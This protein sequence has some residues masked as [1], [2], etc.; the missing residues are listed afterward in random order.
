MHL[1]PPRITEI[2]IGHEPRIEPWLTHSTTPSLWLSQLEGIATC[3]RETN[4]SPKAK[5]AAKPIEHGLDLEKP[6]S[7]LVEAELFS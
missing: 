2:A 7:T 3:N 4:E 1:M 5:P 6:I